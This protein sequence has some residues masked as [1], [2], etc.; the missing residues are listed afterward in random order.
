M[1]QFTENAIPDHLSEFSGGMNSGIAEVLLAPNQLAF[2]GNGTVRGMYIRPRP[3]RRK[4]TFDFGGDEILPAAVKGG[5]WQGA[6][7]YAPDTGPETL[8]AAIGGRLFQFT[9]SGTT[10]TVIERTGANAQSATAPQ[11]WLWQSEKWVIWNDG[12]N[13]PVFFNGLTTT[14]SLGNTLLG[15]PSSTAVTQKA[16]VDVNQPH[17]CLVTVTSTAGMAVGYDFHQEYGMNSPMGFFSKIQDATHVECTVTNYDY[18]KSIIGNAA[19]TFE[20]GTHL[21]WTGQVNPN[22]LPV[23]KMGAYG[24]GRNWMVAADG[25]TFIAGDI[26][27]GASGTVAENFRD[28]VLY[29]KENQFLAGG[30]AFNVPGG[31]GKITALLFVATLDA[32]LG[33]GPVQI[34]TASRGF[35]CDAPLD[36]TTWQ[37]LTNPIL[38]QNLIANGSLGHNATLLSNDD[39]MFRSRDGIRSLIFAR[40]EFDTWGNVPISREVTRIIEGDN[41]ALLAYSSAAVFDNR[42][43]MTASPTQSAQGVY[44]KTIVAL[45]FDPLSSMGGKAPAVY[46]GSW[47]GLNVLQLLTGEFSTVKRCYAFT[48]NSDLNAIELWELLPSTDPAIGD[49]GGAD[50]ITWWFEQPPVF[51]DPDPKKR[52]FKRLIN[53]EI[54]VDKLVG[55]VD[56]QVWYRPDDYPCWISWLEWSE[57]ASTATANSKPQFRPRMGLG[58]PSGKVCDPTTNRPLREGYYFQVKV[59]IRG[60]C[61]YKGMK[62]AALAIPEPTFAKPACDAICSDATQAV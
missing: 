42:L 17:P 45:N 51:R 59:V 57:C 30:G 29:V 3:T 25:V 13:L 20:L 58:E 43:L 7:Y 10:A 40:R 33:Q 22:Q 4:I 21:Y 60:Q 37:A 32:A 55:R 9:I 46:D 36:R 24:L 44:H 39:V 38:K 56:F 61:R 12:I 26:V 15:V 35:S 31:S 49:N 16:F 8:V 50:Q 48:L 34:F 53:G 28:A 52:Q 1:N 5:L 19:V 23:G 2:L 47:P 14:R 27:F 11:E 41:P 54:F 6:C 62:L 18:L